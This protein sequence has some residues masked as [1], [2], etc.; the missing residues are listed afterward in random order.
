MPTLLERKVQQLDTLVAMTKLLNTTLDLETVKSKAVEAV[1]KLLNVEAGSLLLLEHQSGDLIFD[2]AQGEKGEQI[3]LLHI[4]KGTG[5]AGWVAEH[6]EPLIIPDVRSDARFFSGVDSSSGYVTRDLLCVP[7]SSKERRIGVL[8]AVNRRGGK[9]DQDDLV[10]LQALANQVALAI[11]NAQLYL[12]SVTDGLTGLYHH[13]FFVLRLGE[14]LDRCRRYREGLSLVMLDIDFFKK[15]NDTYGHLG[16]DLVLTEIAA[17][18]KKCVRQSDISARYGG[19]EFALLLPYASLEQATQVGER[20]RAAVEATTFNGIAVTISIGIA[21]YSG[22]EEE[23]TR[24]E[25]IGAADQALYRAK[26]NG[27]NRVELCL[28]KSSPSS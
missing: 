25:L 10:I 17:L 13:K 1:R 9:F 16:G 24:E 22:E 18:L 3:H 27:R 23:V 26:D 28:V 21:F 14:E 20:I 2:V 5:I 15:V 8:Q 11:E 4:P 6:G 7:V 19:E 12:E